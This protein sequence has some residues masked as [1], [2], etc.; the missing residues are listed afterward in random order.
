MKTGRSTLVEAKLT[1]A[2]NNDLMKLNLI[3]AIFL[4][5][6]FHTVSLQLVAFYNLH[7]TKMMTK[8]VTKIILTAIES[9]FDKNVDD[10]LDLT[11]PAS[12]NAN[13]HCMNITRAPIISKKN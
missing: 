13:P 12:R 2:E 4:S 9:I 7:V 10:V 6:V 11:A 3:G 8:M 1:A 5:P